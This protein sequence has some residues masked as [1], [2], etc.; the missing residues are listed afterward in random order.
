MA[1]HHSLDNGEVFEAIVVL[2]EDRQALMGIHG[3]IPGSWRD[4]AGQDFKEG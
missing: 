4:F 1:H 3:D 2:A